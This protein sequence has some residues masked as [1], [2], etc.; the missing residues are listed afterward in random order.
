V[1]KWWRQGPVAELALLERG[2]WDVNALVR[3]AG[4]MLLRSAGNWW[5]NLG[6]GA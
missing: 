1:G 5:R 4:R 3:R 2:A 6:A